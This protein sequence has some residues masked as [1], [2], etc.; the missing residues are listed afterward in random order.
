MTRRQ[1]QQLPNPWLWKMVPFFGVLISES[2]QCNECSN[3]YALLLPLTIPKWRAGNKCCISPGK[4]KDD[5]F[6]LKVPVINTRKANHETVGNKLPKSQTYP[7][8]SNAGHCHFFPQTLSLIF[9][10]SN[11]MRQIWQ[12]YRRK[13]NCSFFASGIRHML[14]WARVISLAFPHSQSNR[15]CN[16]HKP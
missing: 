16:P 6:L 2:I 15:W 4:T 5:S 14:H 13:S 10:I 1:M 7:T 8:V 12:M 3:G 9:W 11:L